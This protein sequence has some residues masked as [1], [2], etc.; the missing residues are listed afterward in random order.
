MTDVRQLLICCDGTNNTLT[1]RARDTNVLRL[2]EHIRRTGHGDQ[3]LY[4]DPGV[5]SADT[6]PVTGPGDWLARKWDRVSGLAVGRGAFENIGEAYACLMRH[7]TPG[8]QVWIFGFSRGAFTA[9]SV[10]GMVN[11]FGVPGPEHEALL[12]TLLRIYFSPMRQAAPL[13]RRRARQTAAQVVLGL[14]KEAGALHSREA[15]AAQVRETFGRPADVHFV[16]VWDTVEAIGMPGMQLRITSASTIRS[17]RILHAR[18][19]LA[20]DEHRLTFAPR[21]Y[22]EDDFG[23]SGGERSLRQRWFRGVHADVGGGYAPEES[24]LSDE[25]LAWMVN[26]AHACGLRIEPLPPASARD[27]APGLHHDAAPPVATMH[28]PLHTVPWWAMAGLGVRDTSG[29]PAPREHASVAVRGG[30]LPSVWARPR[31]WQPLLLALLGSL[32]F[33]VAQGWL[34]AGRLVPLPEAM[35]AAM[36]L[37]VAPLQSLGAVVQWKWPALPYRADQGVAAALLADFGLVLSYGYVLGAWSSRAF[38]RLAGLRRIG[39]PVPAWNVLG[40][41]LPL[42]LVGDVLENLLLL[43]SRAAGEGLA[44]LLVGIAGV[45]SAAKFAGLLACAALLVAGLLAP[46]R[47]RSKADA[48]PSAPQASG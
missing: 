40:R 35:A 17:K 31:A 32:V 4:Y 36:Q 25:A 41:A 18:Q 46:R 2:Y 33:L 22:G 8:T 15:V 24:G 3:L 23:E 44:G 21:L 42:L 29:P 16:G 19:A 28:D 47:T 43:A 26:E 37:G 14:E 45:A 1:G 13:A 9:R 39:D 20:L 10:S 27:Q 7:W 34:L 48:P 38:T 30:D 12:P 11:L 5:G 6:L